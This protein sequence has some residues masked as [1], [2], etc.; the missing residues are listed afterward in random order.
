MIGHSFKV[1]KKHEPK[2]YTREEINK[3]D[4]VIFQDGEEA[5]AVS[6]AEDK[7]VVLEFENKYTFQPYLSIEELIHVYEDLEGDDA[8]KFIVLAH[9]DEDYPFHFLC[10][11]D[12]DF[13]NCQKYI[14]EAREKYGAFTTDEEYKEW[15]KANG[16]SSREEDTPIKPKT[17]QS[18]KKK[19][20]EKVKLADL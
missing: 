19:S 16:G 4:V 20:K 3:V 13:V 11:T 7:L 6:E 14:A 17:T 18:N 9:L 8:Y 12:L 10:E 1:K 15:E 2:D 5:H